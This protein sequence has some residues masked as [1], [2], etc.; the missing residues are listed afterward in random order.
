[1]A[2]VP[3]MGGITVFSVYFNHTGEWTQRN[4]Q[5]LEVTS[6][7]I[8]RRSGLWILAG[9]FN[10]EPETFGQ[11][12][13]FARLPGVLVKPATPTFRH[14][15][16]VRCF[17]YFVVH[18]AVACQNHEVRVLEDSGISPHHPVQMKLK[19]SFQGLVTRVQATPRTLPSPIVGCAREPR[20]WDLDQSASTDKRWT[21]LMQ[22]TEQEILGGCDLLGD[23]ARAHTGRGVAPRCVIRNLE[24]AKSHNRS[25]MARDPRWWRVLSNRLRELWLM[26]A[27][28]TRRPHLP[29]QPEQIERLRTHLRRMAN[30]AQ[31]DE[32]R[33]EIWEMATQTCGENELQVLKD[34]HWKALTELDKLH[35]REKSDRGARERGFQRTSGLVASLHEAERNLVSKGCG[36]RRGDQPA[37]CCATGGQK[38]VAHLAC[39]HTKR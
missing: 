11:Y 4:Q 3:I 21:Q 29:Q 5:I 34:V 25:R 38:L 26:E 22:S 18:R 23:E 13:T 31:R 35:K 1:M 28:P 15:A 19:R 32:G 30:E 36:A 8:R 39:A 14:G 24:P 7:E 2:W 12:A 6:R 20:C 17:G 27:L 33:A 10:M 16:S 37:R 9:D